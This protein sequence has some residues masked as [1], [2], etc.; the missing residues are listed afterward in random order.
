MW[1]IWQTLR[2]VIIAKK[3]RLARQSAKNLINF[4]NI[5]V[6]TDFGGALSFRQT[7]EEDGDGDNVDSS[8]ELDIIEMTEITTKENIVDNKARLRSKIN[9]R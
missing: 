9:A 2:M 5:D 7:S 1:C 4:E 8:V 3:Q 6:D